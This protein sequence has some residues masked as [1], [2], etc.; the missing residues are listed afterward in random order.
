MADLLTHLCSAYL[1]KR[2]SV[3]R[4]MTFCMMGSIAPDITRSL[5][6]FI[7]KLDPSITLFEERVFFLSFALHT[8]FGMLLTSYF[9]ALLF[10]LRCRKLFFW[11]FLLGQWLHFLI[12][13]LQLHWGPGYRWAFPFSHHYH[14]FGLIHADDSLLYLPVWLTLCALA[15]R[16]PPERNKKL[17]P[18]NITTEDSA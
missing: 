10:P 2:L 13:M 1:V 5:G 8:P 6:F 9:F 11:N 16:F 3:Q 4:G 14:E 17:M 7:F 18:L 12:D 15:W